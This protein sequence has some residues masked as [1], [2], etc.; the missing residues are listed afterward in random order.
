LPVPL[1]S[2]SIVFRRLKVA[3]PA[4]ANKIIPSHIIK[5]K[6]NSESRPELAEAPPAPN[7]NSFAPADRG[8]SVLEFTPE[9]YSLDFLQGVF[10]LCLKSLCQSVSNS[11]A[12]KSDFFIIFLLTMF[13]TTLKYQYVCQQANMTCPEPVEGNRQ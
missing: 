5:S 9:N 11:V 2:C 12:K 3:R 13:E 1:I 4:P 6:K 8:S 7:V 10:S